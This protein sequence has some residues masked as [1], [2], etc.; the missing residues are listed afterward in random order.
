MEVNDQIHAPTAL[1]TGKKRYS[2][3]RRPQSLSGRGGEDKNTF[4][5][6]AGNRTLVV[7]SVAWSLY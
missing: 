2:L 7:R 3:D 6:R 1:L 4:P 5:T